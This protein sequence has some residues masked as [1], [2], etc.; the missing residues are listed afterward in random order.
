MS[1]NEKTIDTTCICCRHFSIQMPTGPYSDV[2]PGENFD[3]DCAKGVW[4]FSSRAPECAEDSWAYCINYAL[5]CDKFERR[6]G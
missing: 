3:I 6:E 4:C 2:T 5:K 1:G